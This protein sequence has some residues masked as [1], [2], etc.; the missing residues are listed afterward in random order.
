MQW[1]TKLTSIVKQLLSIYQLRYCGMFH[2]ICTRWILSEAF[3]IIE[4]VEFKPSDWLFSLANQCMRKN[5][6]TMKASKVNR[7]HSG[8]YSNFTWADINIFKLTWPYEI[9]KMKPNWSTWFIFK[10][11]S[12]CC[13]V[14]GFSAVLV[15]SDKYGLLPSAGINSYFI[16]LRWEICIMFKTSAPFLVQM[17]MMWVNN[18]IS[19]YRCLFFDVKLVCHGLETILHSS[20]SC[21]LLIYGI[22]VQM[23]HPIQ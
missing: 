6:K 12:K 4:H 20:K 9:K 17:Q 14:N 1:Y 11:V 21:F 15:L 16:S 19:F 7:T 3:W 5:A 10:I 2:T 18:T 8:G 22:N 13:S 23:F